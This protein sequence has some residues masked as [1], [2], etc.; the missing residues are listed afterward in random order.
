L[1]VF[2][3]LTAVDSVI[4]IFLSFSDPESSKSPRETFTVN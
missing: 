4:Y 1:F 3:E 2:I